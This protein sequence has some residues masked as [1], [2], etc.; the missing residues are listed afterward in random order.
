MRTLVTNAI[1]TLTLGLVFLGI[2]GG[3]AEATNDSQ[4]ISQTILPTEMAAGETTQV[5]IT[6]KNT[7]TTTWTQAGLFKIGSRNSADN[8]HWGMSRV[9]LD[10]LDFIA[11]TQLKTFNFTITAPSDPGLYNFQWQMLQEGVNWFGASSTNQL[12]QVG[13]GVNDSQ[14]ISQDVPTS[15]VPGETRQVSVTFKNTGTTTWTRARF[16]KIGSRNPPDNTHWGMSR[17]LLDPS[18]SIA[19]T[20]QKTFTF[21]VTAPT[22]PGLY[23]FQWLTLLEG[24][25]WFGASSA[26]Q[27]IDVVRVNDSQF[28]SQNVPTTMDAGETAQVSVTFKNTGTTTWTRAGLF[29]IG[30]RNPA[31]NT[32]WGMSRVLLDPSDSIAPTQQKTFSFTITAPSDPGLY[33]FQWQMLQEGLNWFGPSSANKVVSVD[34][35]LSK[36][37]VFSKTAGFRHDSIPAGIAALHQLGEEHGFVV[38]ATEDAAVFSGLEFQAFD[39]IVFLN[40]TGDVLNATEQSGFQTYIQEGG[41]FVGIHAASDTEHDWPW[42]GRLVGAYFASHPAPQV[43][44]I[45]VADR[46]HPSTAHLPARWMRNDEWYSFSDNPRGRVHVLAA[47]DER[48]YQGGDMGHDHPIAWCHDFEGGRAWY[49]GGGHTSQSYGEP[50]FLQHLLGGI[51]WTAGLAEGD[52]GATVE[53]NFD[54]IVLDS[55][56]NDPM[57]LAVAADGRV[58]FVERGGTV[59]VWRPDT[60]STVIAGIIN[61]FAELEDGLLGIA[62][63]PNFSGNGWFYV[64]Y[65]PPDDG[66]PLRNVVSRFTMIGNTF[67]ANSEIVLLQIPTQREECCHSA[68]SMAFD[69]SGNLFISTG[70]NTNPFASQGFTPIDERPGRAPFDAQKSSAN[71]NDLRG[72]ILRIRPL[73]NGTYAIPPD[74]LFVSMKLSTRPEVYVMGGR[75]PFRISVDSVTGTLYWGD[76]GPDAGAAQV[77]RGPAGH[78]EFNRTTIAGNFGWPYFVADNKAFYDHDFG[79]GIRAV[80]RPLFDPARPFNDSPNNTGLE[81]LPPAKPAWIWYPYDSSSEFPALGEGG[82]CGMAGPVYHFQPTTGHPNRLPAYYDNT[83]FLYEWSRGW[84]M[85]VHFDD[86]G[87]ILDILPFLAGAEF[88]HPIDMEQGPDGRLYLIEWGSAFAGGNSDAVISR[89]EYRP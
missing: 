3:A 28:V 44:T 18:D 26:N 72:K 46:K 55:N 54:K 25:N 68:G 23:N 24:V 47:L 86:N 76:V 35:N 38:T 63:D 66:G 40:T 13:G 82:R 64:Y 39:T 7:G 14:F 60:Q 87:E 59:K 15:M 42:Y 36:V 71:T 6:F 81:D 53:E 45:L 50:A 80:R 77:G 34:G 62:L 73:P 10:P 56:V 32:R 27:V 2:S 89:I 37:L 11:P 12:I 41:G 74:N 29:K 17:V 69:G 79:F 88:K 30:S 70:D 4:F 78:D 43:A 33:N 83:L 49:T 51:L 22:I 9:L 48:T 75:N 19:P 85:T 67:Q 52:A 1:T 58:I 84:I 21:D 8:T 5:S 16:F 20:Q 61:V 65:S 57:E 31:D